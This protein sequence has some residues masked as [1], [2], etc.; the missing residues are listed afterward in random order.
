MT[1]LMPFNKQLYT[2]SFTLIVV[3]VSGAALT[4]MYIIVDILPS[5]YPKLKKCV[6]T[7]TAPFKW[8]GLNPL[9]IFVGMDLL[10]LFLIIYIKIDDKTVWNLFYKNA[11]H[12]W[13]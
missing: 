10:A 5:H 1:L 8:L 11:F 9:A 2:S 12:S 7:I 13:I 3:A 4:F 6:E